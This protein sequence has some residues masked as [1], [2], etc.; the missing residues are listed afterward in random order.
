VKGKGENQEAK[1][2]TVRKLRSG[3]GTRKIESQKAKG[4]AKAKRRRAAALHKRRA[5]GFAS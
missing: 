2:R 3:W 1:I 5:T 4:K